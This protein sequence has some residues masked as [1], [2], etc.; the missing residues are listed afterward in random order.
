M[1]HGRARL[2]FRVR[3][4]GAPERKGEGVREGE[5]GLGVSLGVRGDEEMQGEGRGAATASTWACPAHS[6]VPGCLGKT[7]TPVAAGPSWA[8]VSGPR[9]EQQVVSL[10]FSYFLFLF[11]FCNMFWHC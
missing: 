7:T 9:P 6:T 3:D 10:F 4:F 11:L 2:G 8:E 5:N 1:V